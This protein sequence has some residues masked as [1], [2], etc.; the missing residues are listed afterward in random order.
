MAGPKVRG[1]DS[2]R[3]RSSYYIF[4]TPRP[5]ANERHKHERRQ[6]GIDDRGGRDIVRGTDGTEH[7]PRTLGP[8]ILKVFF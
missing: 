6:L 7:I 5:V 2:L 8:A 4:P 1:I 3:V